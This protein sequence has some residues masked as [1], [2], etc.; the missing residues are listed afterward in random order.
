M[1]ELPWLPLQIYYQMQQDIPQR[2]GYSA[3]AGSLNETNYNAAVS[4]Q[5]ADTLDTVLWLFK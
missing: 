2:H 5:G 4:A 3:T 1:V